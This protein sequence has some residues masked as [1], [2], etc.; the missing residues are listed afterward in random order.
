MDFCDRCKLRYGCD[1]YQEWLCANNDYIYRLE[2]TKDDER[3]TDESDSEASVQR[4]VQVGEQS[5]QNE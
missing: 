5:E 4:S 2:E 1:D 3:R